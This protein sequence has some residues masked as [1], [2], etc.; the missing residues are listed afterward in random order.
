MSK[1]RYDSGKRRE[2]ER[3]LRDLKSN[4]TQANKDRVKKSYISMLRSRNSANAGGAGGE[5]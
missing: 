5:G 1:E 2:Y 4:P 3:R